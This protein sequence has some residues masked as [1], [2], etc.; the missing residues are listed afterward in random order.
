M[1]P[2]IRHG[3]HLAC[4]IGGNDVSLFPHLI[5]HYRTLGI[6]SFLFIRHAASVEDPGYTLIEE[7]AAKAGITL[8][9]THVGPWTLDLNQR[10]IR[11]AM[12]QHPDDWYV[13]V[14]S[15]EFQVYDRPLPDVIETCERGGYDHVTGCFLDRLG[16]GGDFPEVGP[17]PLWD[18]FPLAGS[19]SA[20]LL[21]ALP[22]KIGLARGW[23]ELTSG[24]HGTADGASLPRASGF[25]Q[26]HHVKWTAS[27]LARLRERAARL[28]SAAFQQ[29]HSTIVRE[30]RRYLAHVEQH[31]GRINIADP[32]F[33]VHPCGSA[34]TDYPQWREVADEAE[35]WKWS[36]I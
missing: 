19:I 11:Y 27:A 35:G 22:L 4:V 21:R 10:L 12:D 20:G 33:R 17:Q 29:D 8:F 31:A 24:Q 25:I 34:Y 2:A 16:A 13:L 7:A 9:H 28:D 3:I 6:E 26:V 18:Q 30:S 32:R 1:V 15:D 36:Q 14:D 5:D 23:V